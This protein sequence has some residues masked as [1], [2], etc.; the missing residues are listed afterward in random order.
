MTSYIFPHH[1]GIKLEINNNNNKNETLEIIQIH[2]NL[3]PY[4]CIEEIQIQIEM[5]LTTF[6]YEKTICCISWN[7]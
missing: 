7:A 6:E 2:A 3:I 5:A 4:T 1:N